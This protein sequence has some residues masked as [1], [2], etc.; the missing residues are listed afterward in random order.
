MVLSQ[1]AGGI[2]S[3]TD[4]RYR[5]DLCCGIPRFLIF[6]TLQ[7]SDKDRGIELNDLQMLA[8]I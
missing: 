5:T 4:I 3:S 1:L 8:L 6:A 2:H 7:L